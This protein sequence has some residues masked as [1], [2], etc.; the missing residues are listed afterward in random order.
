MV[1]PL[2]GDVPSSMARLYAGERGI[3]ELSL[4]QLPGARSRF[5]AE[6]VG[7]TESGVAARTDAMAVQA[8]REALA[9]AGLAETDR[10][11]LVV[12]GTTAG[13]FET[14]ELLTQ[15]AD[16]DLSESVQV[17][18]RTHPLSSTA[19]RLQ[20]VLGRFL[21]TRTVC[22]AC[23]SGAAALALGASWIRE[24]RADVVLAGGADALCR[25]TYSGFGSLAVLDPSP[26]RPFDKTRA[27]L[28]LGEGAAFLVLERA[29]LARARGKVAVAEL[30]GYALGGEA[31]HITNPEPSGG[32]AR[33]ILARSLSVAN[34]APSDVGY[35]N[36][37][38][39]ATP[40]NDSSEAAAIRACFGPVRVPVSSSKGQIGHTL[41]AAGA[42][43]AVIAS[44]VVETRRLPP[45]VGLTV[46]DPACDVDHV[47]EARQMDRPMTVL[48]SS[49]GFGG[50]GGAVVLR[51][52]DRLTREPLAP[53]DI[54]VSGVAVVARGR[55]FEGAPE[56]ASL[57]APTRG[58]ADAPAE[59][60][61]P[62]AWLDAG[63]ARRMDRAGRLSA[64]VIGA[65]I[66]DADVAGA[67][68][69]REAM[70]AISGTA[71]GNVDGSMRFMKRVIDKGAALAS[72]AD[73]PNLV[74]SSPVSHAAIYWGLRG[75]ALATPDLS[76]T[77]ESATATGLELIAGGV[78]ESAVVGSVEEVSQLAEKVLAPLLGV[79]T[80]S[81]HSEGASALLL[82]RA[83]SAAERGRKPLARVRFWRSV[84]GKEAA[85]GA[86]RP[87]PGSKI[88][89]EPATNP[90]ALLEG[91]PWAQVERLTTASIAGDHVGLGGVALAAAA[92][93][94]AQGGASSVL[95]L[96]EAP[97]RSYAFVLEAIDEAR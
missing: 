18:L 23:T 5:A 26:C 9:D 29:D 63:K 15:L 30:V 7:L 37:H 45:T 93:L 22:C 14:E 92:S 78:C 31:H 91:S 97:D 87:G 85:A 65:A 19:D 55:L 48:S 35:V 73:F 41:G 59:P 13:M 11:A 28:T 34:L 57:L 95:V 56:I 88:V 49:F 54:V 68:V 52:A 17:R 3:R 76:T 43:E 4:F 24:G 58:D 51:P 69:S 40:L 42:I 66:R 71:F 53:A 20:E 47:L 38:G 60:T 36:A 90:A 79:R 50:T 21:L 80:L 2:G 25:L 32:A 74:P 61:D 86:P 89:A 62:T 75:P 94:V 64:A 33:A 46:P 39:T 1:T 84:R 6:V 27:G 70:A 16:A 10:V 12:G 72:P 81:S 77:A 96:G 82:E 44:K 8:A 83:S 67:P